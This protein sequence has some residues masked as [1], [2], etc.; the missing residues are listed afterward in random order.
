[1]DCGH[2]TT[3]TD[4]R[5]KPFRYLPGV[6]VVELQLKD[7]DGKIFSRVS[8]IPFCKDC[9]IDGINVDDFKEAIVSGDS[10]I[11]RDMYEFG[12]A[13]SMSIGIV[14]EF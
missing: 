8:G 12:L 11:P 7:D 13:K 14:K 5:G 2:Q 6:K 4:F 3:V 1:M 9:S 10:G